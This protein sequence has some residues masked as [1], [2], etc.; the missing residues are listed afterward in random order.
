MGLPCTYIKNK[1]S[2]TNLISINASVCLSNSCF[3][4]PVCRSPAVL[5]FIPK[6]F[7]ISVRT[8]VRPETPFSASPA[9]LEA[10]NS[11]YRQRNHPTCYCV[12]LHVVEQVDVAKHKHSDIGALGRYGRFLL[13]IGCERRQAVCKRAIR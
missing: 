9:P 2:K 7:L 11:V 13:S 4:I 3:I 1:K 8:P 10:V 6:N 5:S 12:P